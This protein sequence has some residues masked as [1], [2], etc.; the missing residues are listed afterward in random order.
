MMVTVVQ[1]I[2]VNVDIQAVN[3]LQEPAYQWFS[4]RI[5]LG[6]WHQP[7]PDCP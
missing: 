7:G 1:A 3:A 4:D 6:E 5:W 2:T